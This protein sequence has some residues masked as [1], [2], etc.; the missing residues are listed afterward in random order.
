MLGNAMI[1]SQ[2]L[3]EVINSFQRGSILKEYL[4]VISAIT[5][6]VIGL[7]LNSL[8]EYI[9]EKSRQS[10]YR[11]LI[12]QEIEL[13]VE[14]SIDLAR[15]LTKELD[16]CTSNKKLMRVYIPNLATICFEEFYPKLVVSYN[17]HER[18]CINR[19]YNNMALINSSSTK[20]YTATL[21]KDFSTCFN[22]AND[23]FISVIKL[24]HAYSNLYL[25]YKEKEIAIEY[26]LK[27]NDIE[28]KFYQD[29]IDKSKAEKN[30]IG[31]IK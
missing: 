28:S 11:E 19:V 21:G 8:K 4:P 24:Y 25:G 18:E 3:L 10:K 2:Q 20:N 30:K 13:A 1:T 7:F 27:K 15:R 29:M 17:S 22:R 9:T 31:G 23:I 16:E 6:V 12:R 26:F 14:D 5:G